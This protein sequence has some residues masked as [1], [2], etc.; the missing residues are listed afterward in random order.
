MLA[1]V[2]ESHERTRKRIAQEY[3]RKGYRVIEASNRDA[4]PDFLKDC[5]PALIAESDDDNVVVIIRTLRSLKGAN[6]VVD[7]AA[8]VEGK[9][10]W[11][12]ELVAPASPEPRPDPGLARVRFQ[13][14]AGD[15]HFGPDSGLADAKALYLT[16]ML[17]VLVTDLAKCHGI[18]TR[19]KSTRRI[20]AELTFKGIID[21]AMDDDIRDALML[22]DGLA[23][24]PRAA[25]WEDHAR[26][27][28]LTAACEH[29]YA[30]IAQ[31]RAA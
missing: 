4:L 6:D 10:G 8:R 18:K 16:A 12:L 20:V 21:E 13:E 25:A 27:E 9:R 26:L 14:I 24:D 31:D 19:D 1:R 3:R 28:R 11:R 17:D 22:R 29:L 7:L 5:H 2:T 23:H 15:R 30:M